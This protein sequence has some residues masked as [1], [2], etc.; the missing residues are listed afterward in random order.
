MI[1]ID[2]EFVIQFVIIGQSFLF[3]PFSM[4][5]LWYMHI[6]YFFF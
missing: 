5:L 6:L 2:F 1:V 3:K 4:K